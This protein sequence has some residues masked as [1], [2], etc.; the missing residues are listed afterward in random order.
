M[1]YNKD[2][3]KEQLSFQ[4]VYDY[5]AELGGNP[6][7][8]AANG[9]VIIAQ[10]ICH[11][12][13]HTGS[14]KLYYYHNSHLCKCFTECG[15]TFDLFDL[16]RRAIKIQRGDELSL[17]QAVSYVANYFGLSSAKD[18]NFSDLRE[19]LQDW[20]ILRNYQD[21]NSMSK[22][23]KRVEFKTFDESILMHFPRPRIEP[24]L[25][26]GIAQ[27]VMDAHGICYNP[28]SQ[29]IVIPHYDENGVLIGV[30]ERTLIK[31]E[32]QYGK[33]RP[34]I[35]NGV[36]YNHPLGFALYNLE[37]AKEN[38]RR[39]GVAIV[40]E[41]EK[42]CLKYASY[43]GME[44]DICVATCG[45][46]LIQHQIDLLLSY[47]AKEICIAFDKQFQ[48]IGDTE[49]KQWVKKLTALHDKYSKL[50]SIS[51]IFDTKGDMLGYKESPLDRGA[52]VFIQLFK[53]RVKL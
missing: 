9:E 49:F 40:A 46:N 5:I 28:I 24:W 15:D 41:G 8:D 19:R 13:A 31:E 2:E 25:R 53:E 52:D 48:E 26:E 38:I 20:E 6:R 1:R 16:T 50:V 30:R 42:S 45:S 29:G 21:T 27:E 17:P 7:I 14:H 18:E 36:M 34:A 43:F 10:T 39:M 3:I 35:I 33:Y 12:P 4:Q 22:E 23:K 51:F 47:G 11:N 44:N 37:H 32:E